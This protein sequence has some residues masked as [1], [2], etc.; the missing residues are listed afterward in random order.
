M[1][2]N[3]KRQLVIDYYQSIYGDSSL[4]ESIAARTVK[5]IEMGHMTFRDILRSSLQ[6]ANS[7]S[8]V[9]RRIRD[10]LKVAEDR[11]GS[12]NLIRRKIIVLSNWK[13]AS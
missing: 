3:G 6:N 8:G 4:A 13:K 12:R 7:E 2:T 11:T 9:Q 5:K 10:A 1:M